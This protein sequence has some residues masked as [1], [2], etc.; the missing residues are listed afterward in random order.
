MWNEVGWAPG[1][2]AVLCAFVIV[3]LKVITPT[4]RRA[5]DAG[6]EDDSV[7]SSAE[8]IQSLA[9]ALDD[10]EGQL[11]SM[12]THELLADEDLERSIGTVFI[13]AR[14]VTVRPLVIALEAS[15]GVPLR[16]SQSRTVTL[17]SE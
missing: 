11:R 12:P 7:R 6:L 2:A 10:V 3:V 9:A 17:D 8:E 5:R 4:L 1:A 14:V 13:E 15:R 16:V